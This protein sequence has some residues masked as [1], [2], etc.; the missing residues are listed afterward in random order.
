MLVG[1]VCRGALLRRNYAITKRDAARG[2][3]PTD[4]SPKAQ[5]GR[6][7]KAS[8]YATSDPGVGSDSP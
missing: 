5:T 4:E 7:K 1:G 8:Y 3:A 6:V 2:P